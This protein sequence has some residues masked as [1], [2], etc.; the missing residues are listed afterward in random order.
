[1]KIRNL[2]ELSL[3]IVI[4]GLFSSC[5]KDPITPGNYQ[6]GTLPVDTSHW[7]NG[8]GNGGVLPNWPNG[9]SN[10]N[11]LVGT[12]W[13]LTKVMPNGFGATAKSDTI[14]FV[15]NTKYYVGSDTTN[16]AL[17]TL[18]TSQNNVTLTFKPFLPMNYMQC[19]T[20]Q[21]GVG[22]ASGAYITGVDFVNLYNTVSSFKAW[23]KKI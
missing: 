15:T 7:Q 20:N 16:S 8:Y 4:I 6:A 5:K 12:N 19:S 22:F 2:I 14:H 10:N 18:Y 13:V 3:I 1:M 21:L 17:Y 11:E 23:F 9:G